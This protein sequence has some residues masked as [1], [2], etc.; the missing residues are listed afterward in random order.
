LA[1]L[2]KGRKN[3]EHT[4]EVYEEMNAWL[5]DLLPNDFQK[6]RKEQPLGDILI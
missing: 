4:K 5:L 6:L 1:E 3:G 2:E